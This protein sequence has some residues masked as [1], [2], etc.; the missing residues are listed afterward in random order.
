MRQPFWV[1]VGALLIAAVLA[2]AAGLAFVSA[3]SGDGDD[4]GATVELAPNDPGPLT[5]EEE[6][7]AALLPDGPLDGLFRADIDLGPLDRAAAAAEY[8]FGDPKGD[9]LKA[10]G[11][12][13]GHARGWEGGDGRTAHVVVYEMDD[14]KG[15]HSAWLQASAPMAESRFATP[16]GEGFNDL[17]G[18]AE[19][20]LTAWVDG[21]YWYYVVHF[22]PAGA[23]GAA[24]VRTI[25][26]AVRAP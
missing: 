25:V 18:D 19:A 5:E 1:R 10:A 16:V 8:P 21:R 3:V 2:L 26:E 11:F 23:D 9:R 13:R 12:V 20:S 6:A 24:H 17:E 15:F 4:G 7:L 14:P 22:G